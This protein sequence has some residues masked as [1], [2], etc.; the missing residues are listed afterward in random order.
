VLHLGDAAVRLAES[1]ANG[2]AWRA[3][4]ESIPPHR[5]FALL[6]VES[7]KHAAR[8]RALRAA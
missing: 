5:A 8:R 2:V 4:A 7:A 1:I 6:A 3:R